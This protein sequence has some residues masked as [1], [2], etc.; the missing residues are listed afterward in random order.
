MAQ[1]EGFKLAPPQRCYMRRRGNSVTPARL[2]V[3]FHG[4]TS[5]EQLAATVDALV[6]RHEVLRTRYDFLEGCDEPLQII[7]EHLTRWLPLRTI[8][9]D[10]DL[11]ELMDEPVALDPARGPVLVVEP[12]VD[13]DGRR[14]LLISLPELACDLTTAHLLMNMLVGDSREEE[15]L[16]YADL[17]EWLNEKCAEAQ[18]TRSYFSGLEPALRQG[19][20]LP[21]QGQPQQGAHRHYRLL[22]EEGTEGVLDDLY[23]D[24]KPWLL[25]TWA[26]LLARRSGQLQVVIGVHMPGRDLEEMTE[27]LG[28][29]DQSPPMVIAMK[30]DE[31]FGDLEQRV[32]DQLEELSKFQGAWFPEQFADQDLPFYGFQ[33]LPMEGGLKSDVIA[34]RIQS[35]DHPVV[36]SIEP[37]DYRL[38]LRLSYLPGALSDQ[39]AQDLLDAYGTLLY[40][41]MGHTSERLCE[42]SMLGS[43]EYSYLLE[44]FNKPSANTPE[45]P[46]TQCIHLLF[47]ERAAQQPDQLAVFYEATTLTYDQL[48]RAANRLA[49][50]LRHH[51]VGPESIVA[52]CMNRSVDMII[53]VLGVL[54]SGGAYL[55]LDPENPA[56]RLRTIV[57]DSACQA[58]ILLD[59]HVGT[60]TATDLARFP[61]TNPVNLSDPDNLAYVIYTSGSTGLPKGVQIRHHS[62]V[63][64]L[65]GLQRLV[66][67][68]AATRGLRVSMNAPLSFDASMQQIITLTAGHSLY[69]IPQEIRLDGR[70][71]VDYLSRHAI[72]VLDCT[73]THLA[74]LVGAGLLDC[75]GPVPSLVQVAGGA[76]EQHFW[77]QLATSKRTKFFD[78]Y[79]PTECTVDASGCAI[80]TPG[81]AP[82]I[83]DPL[84]NYQL[85]VVDSRLD[86][87]PLGTPGELL[88]GGHGLA[89][90]YLARP[91]LTATAFV[92]HPFTT[93]PGQ[94]LYRSGDLACFLE[95]RRLTFLGRIDDQV[96]LRGFRIELGEIENAL[97][98]IVSV[99]DAVVIA[100]DLPG[101]GGKQLV[102]Y[103]L[104]LASPDLLRANL[105]ARLPEYMVPTFFIPLPSFPLKSSGKLDKAALPDPTHLAVRH[106]PPST[107]SEEVLAA[108]WRDLLGTDSLG[109][110]DNFFELGG[111]SLL[112]IQLITRIR[113]TFR[114]ELPLRET[115]EHPTIAQLGAFLDV[116]SHASALPPLGPAPIIERTQLSFAQQRMWLLHQLVGGNATYHLPSATR[117]IGA[118][119][120]GAL[121]LALQDIC[122]RHE[123]LRTTFTTEGE[124]PL[125]VIHGQ[126]PVGVYLVDLGGL[127]IAERQQA[128]RALL[129]A[130]FARPFD[131]EHGPLVRVK[132]LRLDA[133]EHILSAVMHHLVSDGW[134]LDIWFGELVE[135]YRAHVQDGRTQLEFLPVQYADFAHWQR[136]WLHGGELE[137]QLEYW[138][139]Q[140]QGAPALL[141]MPWDF[142]RPSLQTFNGAAVRFALPQALVDRFE[143][144]SRACNATLF[145]AMETALAM[146]LARFSNQSE[147]MIGTPVANRSL[148]EVEPLIGFFA[149]T[150]VLRNDL[151]GKPGFT[152]ALQRLR[153]CA[154]AAYN[155][156]DIPFEHLVEGLQIERNLSFS[157]L[158]QVMFV[159]L[160]QPRRDLTLPG[161]ELAPIE[162]ETVTAKFD[163]LL[164]LTESAHGLEAALEYNTDLFTRATIE[165]LASSFQV[166]I[167]GIAAAPECAL[168]RLPLLTPQQLRQLVH[169][170]NDTAKPFSEHQTLQGLFEAQVRRT[171]DAPAVWSGQDHLDY[172]QLNQRAN[173]IAHHLIARGI[174]QGDFVAVCFHRRI[175]L[176]EGLLGILKAGATYVPM[177]PIFPHERMRTILRDIAARFYLA[178]AEIAAALGNDCAQAIVADPE[179]FRDQPS[180]NPD[181]VVPSDQ[182]AYIIFTSGSTGRPKGVVLQHRPVVNLIEWVN[183]TYA[184]GPGDRLLFT[185][186]LC[187]DLS[188]YDIFGILAAGAEVYIASE[189][190]IRNP[191]LLM[192][193]LDGD[194]ITFWDS[195][196]ATL[197]QLVPFLPKPGQGSPAL[198]LCFLSGD[199]IPLSLP[200]AMQRAFPRIQ[201]VGLGGATE[202]AIWSNFFDIGEL[203][204]TW[205]SVP[206]GLPIQNAHYHV[207]N[208]ALEPCPIGVAGDLYIGS[209]C[210]SRGYF[211]QPGL[212]AA[213]YLP[214]P[215]SQRP[216]MILYH[217]GDRA[218]RMSDGNLVFLGRLD[219]QVKI[220]GFRI[221]LGEIET[222][223]M[224][225][226]GVRE[227]VAIVRE[228]RVGDRRIAAYLLPSEGAAP[229]A[230]AQLR[231]ALGARLP[232][233]MVPSAFITLEQFPLTANGK[234]DRK[235]LPAPE[236]LRAESNA[237]HEAPRDQTESVLAELWSQVL[238]R[239][240]P[241][242]HESFFDSGGNSLLAMQLVLRLRARFRIELPLRALFEAPTIA[243]LAQQ[244]HQASAADTDLTQLK[245]VPRDQPLPL[246]AAQERLWFLDRLYP[247]NPAYNLPLVL[248]L[249]G[250]L[251]AALFEVSLLALVERHEILR[252]T[253]LDRDGQPAQRVGPPPTSLLRRLDF[254][255][256]SGEQHAIAWLENEARLPFDLAAGPILRCALL[257][258]D[259][260]Q[261][262]FIFNVHHIAF[263]GW[264]LDIL[265]DELR[266][267]YG[268]LRAGGQSQLEP[269]PIQ[270]G[271]FAAWQARAPQA[272]SLRYWRDHMADAPTLELPTDGARPARQTFQGA[273]LEL[274]PTDPALERQ[275]AELAQREGT[276]L[277]N[278]LLATFKLLLFRYTQQDDI[279]VG[280]PFANRGRVELTG[281]I[282][283]FVNTLP[284]RTRFNPQ[285]SFHELLAAVHRTSLDAQSHQALPFE[286]LVEA[287]ALERDPS[288]T[289]LYQVVF[290]FQKLQ[291]SHLSLAP[292][293]VGEVLAVSTATSKFDLTLNLVETGQGLRGSLEYQPQLFG[294]PGIEALAQHFTNLLKAIVADPGQRLSALPMLSSDELALLTNGRHGQRLPIAW[295][296]PFD[297]QA[298]IHAHF[299]RMVARFGDACAVS[300]E[301]DRLSYAQLERQANRIA[302]FLIRRGVR[303]EVQVGLCM[304]RA[305]GLVAAILGILKAGGIY[306]PLDPSYPQDRLS[307][308]AQDAGLALTLCDAESRERLTLD[309]LIVVDAN[310]FADEPDHAPSVALD[311]DNAAYTIYTSGSTGKPKG[312]P[313]PHRNVVRLFNA[314]HQWFGFNEH[315]RW[316][317]F[318][319]YAFDFSVWELWGALFYGGQVVVVPYWVSRD[320]RAFYQLLCRER[321]TVLNQSPSAFGQL[322]YLEAH[323]QLT[324]GER[325]YLR[326][327][328]FGAEAL[329]V[330]VLEPWLRRNPATTLVNMYGITETTVHVT[331]RVVGLA[332]VHHGQ[333]S[334]IGVAIPD[335]TLYVLD[336]EHQPAPL[337]V[338]GEIFVGGAGPARGY[339]KRPGLT[340]ERFVPDP[341]SAM[342]GSRLYRSGDRARVF[343]GGQLAYLGRNDHQVKIRG[344]R[345]ELGEI[346]AQLAT[347]EAVGQT[348]VRNKPDKDGRARLVAY[349]IPVPGSHPASEDLRDF[350]LARL[351]DYMV[352]AGFV[353]LEQF[354][355]TAHG[356]L[357]LKAL[358]DLVVETQTAAYVAPRSEL[359]ARLAEVW[360][361][362]LGLEQVSVLDN[363]FALGGDSILS[364][365]LLALARKRGLDFELQQLFT[366]QTVAALASALGTDAIRDRDWTTAAP[367][368]LIDPATRQRLPEDVEDA[369]PMSKLQ[370]GMIYHM[371][372]EP[373]MLPY[374]NV[375]SWV[376]K[377]AV[378][379]DAFIQAVQLLVAHHPILRTGL[380][381]STYGEPLQLVHRKAELPLHWEDL[382]GLD[383]SEQDRIAERYVT[384]ERRR[385]FDLTRP[386]L[387][388]F[389][390]HHLDHQLFRFSVTECHAILDGWSLH[391][392]FSELFRLFFTLLEGR[393]VTLE[394]LPYAYRDF[395]KLEQEALRE[396]RFKAYW[397]QKLSGFLTPVLPVLNW[398]R[399][400]HAGKIIKA[401]WV[402]EPQ[403]YSALT[404]LAESAGVPLKS[405][406]LAAHLKTLTLITGRE[407]IVT[408]LA[409]HGRP[410]VESG[411][412][413]CGLFL[414]ILPFRYRLDDGPWRTVV[415]RL[416]EAEQEALPYRRYPSAH[417][418]S[419]FGGAQLFNTL[420]NYVHFHSMAWVLEAGLL[421]EVTGRGFTE[422]PNVYPLQPTFSVDPTGER[423]LVTLQSSGPQGLGPAQVEAIARIYRA[424]IAHMVADDGRNHRDVAYICDDHALAPLVAPHRAELARLLAERLPLEE[425]Q[426]PAELGQPRIVDADGQPVAVGTAG[427]LVFE[428]AGETWRSGLVACRHA[429]GTLSWPDAFEVR[430]QRWLGG[431]HDAEL[432]G[433]WR[434]YLAGAPVAV[435]L[436]SDHRRPTEQRFRCHVQQ[437]AL[438]PALAQQLAEERTPLACLAAFLTLV[439][440]LCGQRE[441]VVSVACA[442]RRPDLREGLEGGL[443]NLLP[444]RAEITGTPSL[445]AFAHTLGDQW[446]RVAAHHQLP[447]AAM[448]DLLPLVAGQPST[449]LL[450][451]HRAGQ[452]LAAVP[453]I[454]RD[455]HGLR[456]RYDL[457]LISSRGSD[458]LALTLLVSADLFEPATAARLASWLGAVLAQLVHQPAQ[459]IDAFSFLSAHERA[460][461]LTAFNET[462]RARPERLLHQLFEDQVTRTPAALAAVQVDRGDACRSYTYGELDRRANR[463]AHWLIG[464]GVG[465]DRIVGLFVERG[466]DF[467][468]GLLGILKAGAA[469]LPVDITY[470]EQRVAFMLEDASAHVILTQTALLDRLPGNAEPLCLDEADAQLAPYADDRPERGVDLANIAYVIY[471]SGSTG[472]PKGA[473]VQ[474]LGQG[475]LWLA[476]REKFA[477]MPGDRVMQF[478]SPSFDASILELHLGLLFGATLYLASRE[479]LLPGPDL[480]HFLRHHQITIAMLVP[481]ALAL[482]PATGF[483]ALRIMISAGEAPAPGLLAEW[484]RTT[485]T[486]NGYGP[487]ETTVVV[488]LGQCHPDEYVAPLGEALANCRF[489]IL[490]RRLE[491]VPLGVPGALFIES[492]GVTRGYH[493]RGALTAASY[494]P[495]PFASQAGAR[496]YRSG[497]LVR[498]LADGRLEY[499]GRLDHQV[500]IRGY[501]IE[502]GEIEA[503]IAR[504]PAVAENVVIVREDVAG[505]KRLVAYLRL[506]EEAKAE[507][508]LHLVELQQLLLAKLPAYMVP[509]AFVVLDALPLLPNGKLD[510]TALPRP[511]AAH[512]AGERPRNAIESA[513]VEMWSELLGLP[514]AGIHDNFFELGGHSLSATQLISRIRERFRLELALRCLFQAPTPEGLALELANFQ[515]EQT[516]AERPPI[517]RADR[518]QALPL[519]YAQERLWFL[520]RLNPGDS[521]YN[522]PVA[523]R[524]RGPLD[525]ELFR[526]CFQEIVARHEALRTRFH[527]RDG[528]PVQ[529]V[530][531]APALPLELVD[532]HH[533]ERA[534]AERVCRAALAER[535]MLPFDLAS[536]LL[537]RLHLFKLAEGDWVFMLNI[538]HIVTDGWSQQILE[539]E[540]AALYEAFAAGAPS[541]LPT[542][543]LQYPDYA[544]WQRQWLTGA[545][546]ERQLGY[547]TQQLAGAPAFLDL[548][549]DRPRPRL[550]GSRGNTASFHLT[551]AVTT[552]MT[553]LCQQQGT[554]PFMVLGAAFAVLLARYA[555]V[556][557]LNLGTPVANRTHAEIEQLVGFFVNTLVLRIDLG[558]D[559]SFRQL[560]ERVRH[561][562]L[563]AY[564]HQD[565][566]FEHLVERLQPERDL[567]TT[568]LFQVLFTVQEVGGRQAMRFSS[569]IEIEALDFEAPIAK[570]DLSLFMV[571]G[572]PDTRGM[573]NYNADLFDDTTIDRLV[574]R[575][576]AVCSEL[577]D[578]PEAPLH[579]LKLLA[580]D[581]RLWLLRN[582]ASADAAPEQLLDLDEGF[583]AQARR[584]PG[585]LALCHGNARLDYRQLDERVEALARILQQRGI[586][587]EH[588][589]GV[590][591]RREPELLICLL[592]VLRCGAA[593]VPLDPNYPNERLAFMLADSGAALL[594]SRH[595][596][597]AGLDLPAD[598]PVLPLD[599]LP[600]EP[601]A[602]SAPWPAWPPQRLAYLI[603]T[604]GSTGR[605]KAVAIA[606]HS[607][608]VLLA[609]ARTLYTPTDLAH[610]LAGTSV[611]FDLSIFE[612]FLPLSV[613]GAV[614]LADNALALYQLP[615]AESITLVN[616]VPSVAA[617]FVR[618]GPL[619]SAI[620]VMNL[621]GELLSQHLVEALYQNPGLERLYDLYGPSE[622]TTYSTYVLRRPTAPA[623]IGRPI[624]ATRA[625]LLDR[626]L[627][628]VP[629]DGAG[630]LALAGAGLARGY[631]A[632][633]ALTA[634]RFVP[635]PFADRPGQRLYLTGD[636]A[637]HL[638]DGQLRLLGR[639][640]HQVKI[641]GLRVELGELE[642]LLLRHPQVREAA[643]LVDASGQQLCAFLV[644]AASLD[645]PTLQRHLAASLPDA[646]IPAR[647]FFL[648][649][650]PL[651]PNRKLDRQALLRAASAEHQRQTPFVAPTTATERALVPLWEAL[652]D[653]RPIGIEDNFF[654]LGGHSLLATRLAAAVRA[655]LGLE[656]PVKTLFEQPTI[657]ALARY[658]DVAGWAA[659]PAAPTAD[660][661]FEEE[662]LL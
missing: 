478:S 547:W 512:Q 661:D 173:R 436:P 156:Q 42:F 180:H 647:W 418:Q 609:W 271:D 296:G 113:E 381:L 461:V 463:I 336:Q 327:V 591:L 228:D 465:P 473:L 476:T 612:L 63:N 439:Y 75:P 646:L 138:R 342:P 533:L 10:S 497:D 578:R 177:D 83:G 635:D 521:A 281:L 321:V 289:P 586:G 253:Y 508:A 136:Q 230:P 372:L 588:R 3:E 96:K 368:A 369:Y 396:P 349:V 456:S 220:R 328:V 176:V 238:G 537:L 157:P 344:F 384:A 487:T 516:R 511:E 543:A 366:H 607:A 254:S 462:A 316:S 80:T 451:C 337:G 88:I 659:R 112:A 192:Q 71:M 277:F 615:S 247:N 367:F 464:R 474:H 544:Q 249:H 224:E 94:R 379:R 117:L 351:P 345:I 195:A 527:E 165:R 89:R 181:L 567:G 66:Y 403:Q 36:L 14:F 383:P 538:H 549:T 169:G 74:V 77:D 187:F 61:E 495:N 310:A 76:I 340:A 20:R 293:L 123:V 553:R 38:G 154:L 370:V 573:L 641:R 124:L 197:L 212:S 292:D 394:P 427:D 127:P 561:L 448:A 373:E 458:R 513:L 359:E 111:H 246:T 603:Y 147:V 79:G 262:L 172:N 652:L 650:L 84:L 219:A 334:P 343:P 604:S 429:D 17:S 616:T 551:P 324:A 406:L 30:A 432:F 118:L 606:A 144:L 92:P 158:F 8:S 170:W 199:W 446:Q 563:D 444:L 412:H 7:E 523:Y 87:V 28:L 656:L 236:D 105:Q 120:L 437:L 339:F 312:V 146:L 314:T 375:D 633:P 69:I 280:G 649:S 274:P 174:G 125:Q 583:R 484:S 365:R 420:F 400:A 600:P 290:N 352:P 442:N 214:D 19:T 626:D 311:P 208:G 596:L 234:L 55:P 59:D 472:R 166:L 206:Y 284:L 559:P 498:Q 201:V 223:L 499:L 304:Q 519:S 585:A 160:K 621:A 509:A 329:D 653:R 530:E 102:A 190:Q 566:P 298:P 608:A 355:M 268:A 536:G 309:N 417:L 133:R 49:H 103:Y 550:Q 313:V 524:T 624:A 548:P 634:A 325:H 558:G 294:R 657:F 489:Y 5:W 12:L 41:T 6:A 171:P 452:G 571:V 58:L 109:V 52:L 302:H 291:P 149:N 152:A 47:E 338:P 267:L 237:A 579:Q 460:E 196:P 575:F 662:E 413:I 168:E 322:A 380:H 305:T 126:L 101:H 333:D 529:S 505:D 341:F 227:A 532:L 623:S 32:E 300:C 239:E 287:L 245:P 363:F 411:E 424:V 594:L 488:T 116:H 270:F 252:T 148:K 18:Q 266:A 303:P 330:K 297:D 151:R 21:F 556:S 610:V 435:A 285:G 557:E 542:L 114:I 119:Q 39:A 1:S 307:F 97:R 570:F 577:F 658:L 469:Y 93:I 68:G 276:T 632:R 470:P 45:L 485:A 565:L 240:Q 194:G 564:S 301:Q 162:V 541:P 50:Y 605:P 161:L 16:Q 643:V 99:D 211:R 24:L 554:T 218:S 209:D 622:D 502:I 315:D 651:T 46:G 445:E 590:L 107:P 258:L 130:E 65:A 167:E 545:V 503:A 191:E 78:I 184:V 44:T 269:L 31:Y 155:H 34:L 242:I 217:T 288:R 261:H 13:T 159:L 178:H 636:L 507:Q 122:D 244:L 215:F 319:S 364:V 306:V 374:H 423:I 539:R 193:V 317:L 631:L 617:E 164:F 128:V 140:L 391:Q 620:R 455:I 614:H 493:R 332:D 438:A 402:I 443:I 386:T 619:P 601:R 395:I 251:D 60:P 568:P 377:G 250:P 404:T 434:D 200:P 110:D 599:A 72:D 145:M 409:S 67:D 433:F 232:D 48:N 278:V 555:A 467:V 534:E 257:Q 175:E 40:S 248:R 23:D 205:K 645:G 611:C 233:Y 188:V 587:C 504:N 466:L 496:M 618:Q 264:S 426:L 450:Y 518:A 35:S 430:Q 630:E 354:P 581:E 186:S 335:L 104:G 235:A 213:R 56:E 602:E 644:T 358:P 90:G 431:R 552:A 225:Q 399:Q 100:R 81:I 115:F 51:G 360:A 273:R 576:A 353:F 525:P 318:H 129:N 479:R 179:R 408:G 362:S 531:P 9:S 57:A 350:L 137:R 572:G 421:E 282:G 453:G 326:Y 415:R 255:G 260:S 574:S 43:R 654:A 143:G 108:I 528:R 4:D 210:L 202:A 486:F 207:L 320:A 393:A 598:L 491:P 62:P 91:R 520:D 648:E 440:R 361:E 29:V 376:F 53:A 348:V 356:K 447:Q 27:T 182:L 625:Y 494:L 482:L 25:A 243:T 299:Q 265:L 560:L 295:A 231:E 221:E 387:L 323:E 506:H 272:D 183:Q 286:Q 480:I 510:K 410:E 189:E 385:A 517:G 256:P 597:L 483:P 397:T 414:N 569:G 584:N 660:E 535:A 492:P 459:A 595:D 562:A 131:L 26:L 106:R 382:R 73:P 37:Y 86:L 82:S 422:E 416:F 500:K 640:D 425:A 388:R 204:P 346:Q 222:V 441:T 471:T 134:S 592:A 283:F 582:S 428:R 407:D 514:T 613:G 392:I 401:E 540:F 70:A 259:P 331:W 308:I 639:L 203:H 142:G 263:D 15:P 371:E 637:R 279:V 468:A 642:N 593:Y 515:T 477:P 229:A 139:L 454:T 481:S 64:L 389:A 419:L 98:E 357:D 405:L 627:N 655:E 457:A 135:L 141:E 490:D 501:R 628:L 629:R 390:V 185:T 638:A 347:H 163:L 33:Y 546:L 216:G 54:K 22:L 153:A 150:L 378:D 2:I 226:P 475:N 449:Q 398:D 85:Y 198:R 589:V 526:R 275:L 241:S 11:E 95:D 121:E 522:I 580:E 132:A